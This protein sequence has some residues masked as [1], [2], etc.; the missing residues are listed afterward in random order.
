MSE[1]DC[2]PA[3]GSVWD[4]SNLWHTTAEI[5]AGKGRY[6]LRAGCR[7]CDHAITRQSRDEGWVPQPSVI[8]DTT[9]ASPGPDWQWP[10]GE[11]A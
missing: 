2:E 4:A 1:H 3:P 6:P 11:N 8:I 7:T 10:E 5:A 9:P